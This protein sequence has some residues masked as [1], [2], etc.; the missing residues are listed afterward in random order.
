MMRIPIQTIFMVFLVVLASVAL[1]TGVTYAGE[2]ASE[3]EI[4][5]VRSQ[6]ARIKTMAKLAEAEAQRWDIVEPQAFRAIDSGTGE[7]SIVLPAR[8]APYTIAELLEMFPDSF[9]AVAPAT[10]LLKEHL[11]VGHG[12]QLTIS[13]EDVGELR[14]L[15]GP[16]R[17][18]T[19]VSYR[20][21]I[22]ITGNARSPL[23]ITSWDPETR[24]PDR[25]LRDGRA[26]VMTRAGRIDIRR[27]DFSHL[28][29]AIGRSS[30]VAWTGWEDEPSRGNVIG[31][32]FRASYFGVYTFEAVDMRLIGNEFSNN[33]V[34]GFDP[35][36]QSNRF[37][38][39]FNVA[40]GNGRH[41]FIFSRGCR[42]NIMRFNL[43]YG[44]DWHG[45]VLDDGK[46]ADDGTMRHAFAVPSDDNTIEYNVAWS[47]GE[48]GIALEGGSRNTIRGNIIVD[49]P[50]GTS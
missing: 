36:D 11:V 27:A 40:F 31:S 4:A 50:A 49:S 29:F 26:Y 28:G 44:N 43:S 17:F 6:D 3:Q 9:D 34:Y 10:L 42:D 20:G 18:V 7:A 8:P 24:A 2:E 16:E 37:L 35:H 46:V 41:G 21:E 5:L 23:G 30:G 45:F 13:R 12:A 19:I 32:R 47:N 38:V 39:Q 15:S 14:L 1:G 33:M 48:V 22:D 25:E